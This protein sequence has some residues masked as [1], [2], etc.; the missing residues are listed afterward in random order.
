MEG[1]LRSGSE[2]VRAAV[3]VEVETLREEQAKAMRHGGGGWCRWRR[4]R[5]L[6]ERSMTRR[7]GE[8]S[9]KRCIKTSPRSVSPSISRRPSR[10]SL[11]RSLAEMLVSL[12]VRKQLKN[13][14]RRV[15]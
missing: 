3:A 14:R 8:R 2:D 1:K 4:G 6:R 10:S 7:F 13:L 15:G 11:H 12:C 9:H 5:V